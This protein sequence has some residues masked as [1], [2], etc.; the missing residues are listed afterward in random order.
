ME[1]AGI[2]EGRDYPM[3]MKPLFFVAALAA[4]LLAGMP[5]AG[6]GD[7]Q[8]AAKKKVEP[9][10]QAKKAEI[11][12]DEEKGVIRFFIN[13]KETMRLDESGLHVEGNITYSGRIKDFG[14]QQA[15]DEA[16]EKG[17]P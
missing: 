17:K 1:K 10:G 7:N 3:A 4:S 11:V 6:A 12:V 8:P 14:E 5:D 13:G 16:A 9:S 15:G 2:L